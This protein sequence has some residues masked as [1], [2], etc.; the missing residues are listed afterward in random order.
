MGIS[1]VCFIA[2][3]QIEVE[4]WAY[5]CPKDGHQLVMAD[6]IELSR[7]PVMAYL[8]SWCFRLSSLIGTNDLS[9]F[10]NFGN[11]VTKWEP[12]FQDSKRHHVILIPLCRNGVNHVIILQLLTL[13]EVQVSLRIKKHA[14]ERQL[15]KEAWKVT[16]D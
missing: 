6:L 2:V 5:G 3:Q 11:N 16:L 8:V 15:R 12:V 7:R 9:R 10:S 14:H 13:S 1:Q 4:K